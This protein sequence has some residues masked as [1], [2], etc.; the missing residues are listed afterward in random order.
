MSN[1]FSNFVPYTVPLLD[2][3]IQYRTPEHYYQASKSPF[4]DDWE[5]IAALDTPG[6]AKR[7]GKKLQLRVNWD[8]VKVLVMM[9]V[10]LWRIET[11]PIWKGKLMDTGYSRI[12]E[13]NTWHDLYWGRCTCDKCQESGLNVLGELLMNIRSI[14]LY[15][16]VTNE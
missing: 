14:I 6:Q 16:K 2:H 1:W 8:D 10:L 7:A 11:D 13:W 4:H 9:R 3:G 15:S 12:T 5:R